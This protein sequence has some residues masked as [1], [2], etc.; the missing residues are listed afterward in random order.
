MRMLLRKILQVYKKHKTARRKNIQKIDF[1]GVLAVRC[2][3]LGY[4]QLIRPK[5]STVTSELKNF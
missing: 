5:T 4:F 3:V 2:V 1:L